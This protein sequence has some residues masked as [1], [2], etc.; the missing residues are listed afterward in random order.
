L[1]LKSDSHATRT[2]SHWRQ[3][4][5]IAKSCYIKRSFTGSESLMPIRFRFCY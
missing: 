2:I 4:Q 5:T 1:V 3:L